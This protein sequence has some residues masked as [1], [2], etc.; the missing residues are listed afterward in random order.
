MWVIWVY[1][2][3][4]DVFVFSFRARWRMRGAIATS[5][6]CQ[7]PRTNAI[8]PPATGTRG[9]RHISVDDG[10]SGSGRLV[11]SRAQ[12]TFRHA[13]PSRTARRRSLRGGLQGLGRQL[14]G[15]SRRL[16]PPRTRNYRVCCSR[17]GARRVDRPAAIVNPQVGEAC[18]CR[19]RSA[20]PLNCS[21][22][23]SFVRGIAT[24]AH[25]LQ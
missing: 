14:T 22:L 3:Y 21:K 15:G 25:G 1:G 8:P 23:D 13:E 11:P 5:R 7:A 16:L 19:L 2:S 10:C 17:S 20:S 18:V 4:G 12:A 9:N 6:R 24:I